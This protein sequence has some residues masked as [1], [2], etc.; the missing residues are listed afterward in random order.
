M[1]RKLFFSLIL[2][3]ATMLVAV[4]KE[5]TRD[6]S[7]RA[8]ILEI[9]GAIGPAT[10]QYLNRGFKTAHEKQ[11]DLIILEMNTPGGLVTSTREIITEILTAKVPVA[12]YVSPAGAH[13]ASAGTYILYAGHVAAMTPGTNVGA[14]TPVQM[15]GPG[16]PSKDKD[17]EKKKDLAEKILEKLTANK[18]KDAKEATDKNEKGGKSDNKKAEK[19]EKKLGPDDPMK[20]KTVNDLVAYIKS[21]AQLRD[22]NVEW[23][24]K[25]VREA[26]SLP[27]KEALEMKVIDLTARDMGELLEKIDGRVVEVAK[28]KVTIKTKGMVTERI[29]PDWQMKFLSVITNPN[30]AFILMLIGIYGIIFEFWHPGLVGPGV[31]GGICLLLGLYA[32]NILPLNY[33][34]AGLVLLG[35]AFMTAEAFLPSFGILGIGGLIGFIVGATL[36]FDAESPEFRLSWPVIISTSLFCGLLFIIVLGF[37][38]RSFRK[39]VTTGTGTMIGNSAEILEWAKGEG[40]IWADGERWKASGDDKFKKGQRVEIKQVDGLNVVVGEPSEQS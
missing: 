30:V 29:L 21:L 12:V 22:R 6:N 18:K 37:A 14:A 28:T 19:S 17:G 3:V 36:L 2:I 5:E 26:A 9:K 38:W 25:A 4:A 39:P 16:G 10:A 23:A 40:F 11:V 8:A 27:S 33:T 20:S 24:E 1:L 13:A 34:G 31:I 32:M 35:L 7:P 15:G